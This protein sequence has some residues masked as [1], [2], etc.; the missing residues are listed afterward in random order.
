M[1]F[2]A[3]FA[4]RALSQRIRRDDALTGL[5]AAGLRRLARVNGGEPRQLDAALRDVLPPGRTTA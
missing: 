4:C 2:Q 3:E 1:T 5:P